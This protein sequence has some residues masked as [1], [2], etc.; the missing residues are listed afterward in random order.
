MADFRD[1][2]THAF[3]GSNQELQ[4]DLDIVFREMVSFERSGEIDRTRLEESL[5]EARRA[6][7]HWVEVVH[8]CAD[9]ADTLFRGEL[10]ALSS[11]RRESSLRLPQVRNTPPFF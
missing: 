10:E 8:S 4:R 7:E 5:R 6:F 2:K 1:E 11:P 3:H 9:Q